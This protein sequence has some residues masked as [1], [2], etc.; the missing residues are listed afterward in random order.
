MLVLWVLVVLCVDEPMNARRIFSLY[1]HVS[2][3]IP[4]EQGYALI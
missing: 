1:R 2:G 4:E 3:K